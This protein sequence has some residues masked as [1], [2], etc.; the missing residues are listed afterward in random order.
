L[1]KAQLHLKPDKCAWS[2]KEISFLGFTAVAGKGIRRSDDKLEAIRE[3]DAPK[4]VREVR[5]FLG[6]TNFY[7]AF[8][9]HYSDICSPMTA[10]TGKGVS[11]EWT[12]ECP[13]AFDELKKLLRSDVFLAA[14]DW[15]KPAYLETDASNVA[16]AGV[17]SQDGPDGI[18]RPVVMFS[19]K[20]RDHEKNWPVHDKELYDPIQPVRIS[21][22]AVIFGRICDA[23]EDGTVQV[24][25]NT[26]S[27]GGK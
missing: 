3:W 2:Q 15:D 18:R 13:R 27:G 26:F 22:W 5:S 19:H 25:G 6:L 11:F 20:F 4:N 17:I 14:H 16:Y 9:P 10:L 7:G 8:I 12:S 21:I 1:E 23:L 24:L